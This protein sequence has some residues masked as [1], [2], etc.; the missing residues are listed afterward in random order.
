MQ[1]AVAAAGAQTRLYT[2]EYN[3]FNYANDPNGG[4]ADNYANWYRR[5]IENINNAGYGQVVTGVGVQYIAD[6]RTGISQA[7][8]PARIEQVL[9][10]L[11]VTGLPI[12]LTEFSVPAVSG[13][14]TTT[15]QRSAQIYNESLRMMYGSP[16]ATSFLIWEAWPP[17]TTDNTTIID[18][19]WNLRASGQALV[20]LLN[21]WTTPTQSLLVGADGTVDFSGFYG[22]YEIT[23]GSQTFDLSLLK[24]TEAYSLIVAPGDYN[25]DGSVDAADY[26]LWRDTLGSNEDLRADGNGDRVVDSSDY[27][28]WKSAFGT[29]SSLGAAAVGP[30]GKM[31][32]EPATVGLLLVG[33]MLFTRRNRRT[34]RA[35]L[36][37]YLR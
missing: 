28:I 16:Q 11:S 17:A 37:G 32:P 24:G 36:R 20:D 35:Q 1:D 29:E 13:G 23:I 9:Q 26:T 18:A 4:A 12:T 27:D 33:C 19:N 5:N 2:N 21:S 30:A 34:S 6:A 10:N 25:G 8:S 7:H 15:E 14:V 3:I 31:A 22:D